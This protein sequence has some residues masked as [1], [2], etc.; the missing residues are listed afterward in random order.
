M[1]FVKEGGV[2]GFLSRKLFGKKDEEEKGINTYSDGGGEV[3]EEKKENKFMNFVKGIGDSIRNFDG[4]PGS[5][6]TKKEEKKDEKETISTVDYLNT[7]PPIE[8]GQLVLDNQA[9]WNKAFQ[10]NKN[11]YTQN[12][13][14]FWDSMLKQFIVLNADKTK[15]LPPKMLLEYT[16]RAKA[17]REEKISPEGPDDRYKLKSANIDEKG[18]IQFEAKDEYKDENTLN[19]IIESNNKGLQSNVF[20]PIDSSPTI[21]VANNDGGGEIGDD[22][23]VRVPA[24]Q[25]NTQ[26]SGELVMT[27]DPSS[28]L[29]TIKNE[30]LNIANSNILPHQV[31]QNLK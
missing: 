22:Q 11:K 20:Q 9:K 31:A 29:K 2:A 14:E 15:D 17:L 3:K 30:Q 27:D 24:N 25:P 1:N 7:L 23:T 6:E 10:E 12:K 4:R 28:F 18:N 16:N 19:P 13:K 21:I 8:Q 5:R 26:D